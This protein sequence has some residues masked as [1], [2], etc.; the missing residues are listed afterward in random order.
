M[1]WHDLMVEDDGTER[2]AVS[3]EGI[4]NGDWVVVTGEL[5]R[6]GKHTNLNDFWAEHIE[7]MGVVEVPAPI[8][9]VEVLIM[10]S[11]PPQYAVRVVSGLR[12][13]LVKFDHLTWERHGDTIRVEVFNVEPASKDVVGPP[14]YGTVENIIELGADFE[15]GKTYTVVVNDVT[16]T[17][18]AQ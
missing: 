8:E 1:V 4:E 2:L 7:T 16:E 13:G 17:F 18:V 6:E 5:K 15:S 9:S 10:E 3:V 14:V 12:H 11:F